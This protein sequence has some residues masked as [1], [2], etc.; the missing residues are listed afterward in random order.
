MRLPL[1]VLAVVLSLASLPG[2]ADELT[3]L[4]PGHPR[5]LATADDWQLLQQRLAVEPDLA[6]YHDALLQ[7]AR[8]ELKRPPARY[9]KTGKRLLAVSRAVVQRVL[10][11]AYAW[12][13]TGEAPFARRAEAEML[14]VAAFPDWNPSHF[15]DVGEATAA[16]AIGYDWLF[17][18]LAPAARATI[19]QAIIEKGLRPGLLVSHSGK[20]WSDAENNWNQVCFGGLSLGALAVAEEEPALAS[21]LLH[22]ARTG[23]RHGLAPYAP[24]GVYPE[25][26]SYWAYGTSYQV[27]MI[28]ALESALGTDWDL[29]TSPGF[30]ASAGAYLQ[31]TGPT[32]RHFNFADGSEGASFQ[33]AVFWFARKLADPGLLLFE[34]R[35]LRSPEL[36]AAAVRSNRCAPLAALWWPPA[37]TAG[38]TTALPLRW[39]GRGAN[40]IAA[41]RESWTDPDSLYLALKGGAAELNHAHMD[42]GSFVLEADGVRWAVDL[43]AQSYESLESKGVDLWNRKQDSQR[44]T[45]YRL[46]NFSHNTLTLGGRPH[47]VAGHATLRAIPDGAVVDLTPVFAGQATHVERT[48]RLQSGRRVLIADELRG[49]TPASLVRWQLATR[50]TVSLDGRT[51]TLRQDGRTLTVEVLAPASAAFAVQ[52]AEPP[53]DGYNAPNPGVQ[54]LTFTVP[55][56]A[57]GNLGLEVLL[58]PGNPLPPKP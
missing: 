15:L 50:A 33:P 36:T 55:A 46:N 26:P 35:L 48:F 57:D 21:A 40:P 47:R 6:A 52:P 12:R 31:A 58:T 8:A 17:E 18:A 4:R 2:R 5:L 39:T 16:L 27:I 3:G 25:G 22:D 54:L 37:G 38:A 24:D 34:R 28:A 32:G 11:L 23:I 30:L 45:V 14:A 13:T 10:L 1:L 53:A 9:E 42:A 56:P 7:A 20:S 51:A 44:W 29:A 49:L 43:G 41:L 19:R